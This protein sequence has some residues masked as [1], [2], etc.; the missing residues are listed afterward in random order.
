VHIEEEK[1][2]EGFLEEN[3]K[4]I[5]FEIDHPEVEKTRI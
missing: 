1:K 2:V 3:R 4:L 5:Q